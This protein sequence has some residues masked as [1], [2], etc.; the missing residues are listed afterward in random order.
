MHFSLFFLVLLKTPPL[1]VS[2]LWPVPL[3]RRL[4][5]QHPLGGGRWPSLSLSLAVSVCDHHP[6]F[7]FLSVSPPAPFFLLFFSLLYFLCRFP[8]FSHPFFPLTSCLS[9]CARGCLFIAHLPLCL[10]EDTGMREQEWRWLVGD[11]D[12]NAALAPNAA[13]PTD[14]YIYINLCMACI[15]TMS[16]QS[17]SVPLQWSVPWG[18]K[19]A[20]NL[21]L[22]TLPCVCSVHVWMLWLFCMSLVLCVNCVHLTGYFCVKCMFQCLCECCTRINLTLFLLLL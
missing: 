8:L 14:I 4:C 15:L 9:A 19:K 6:I 20:S 22:W 7:I 11:D 21:F 1:Y 2:A 18:V 3:T 5:T 12:S 17:V 13:R 10:H 16:R